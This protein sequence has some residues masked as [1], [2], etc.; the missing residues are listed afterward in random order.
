[1]GQAPSNAILMGDIIG[2]ERAEMAP[3]H[4]RFNAE[5]TRRNAALEGALVS[6]LTITLGDEF[7]GLFARLEDAARTARDMRLALLEDGVACRFVIGQARID[8][9]VNAERA[10]NMMGPGLGRAR[11]MLNEKRP[12]Q[13]YR[14]SLPDAPLTQTLLEAIGRAMGVIERGWTAQQRRDIAA[15]LGG[16]SA[17]D[18]AAARQV[19][20][21][22]VYKVL[23]AG[24]YDT[25]AA[26]W[27]AA[28]DALAALDA[29]GV[30]K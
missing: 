16:A 15:A 23:R 25:Y 11:D 12:H 5:I 9:P 17:Q 10:W 30:G 28:S 26:L 20:D 21:H 27:D 13:F 29:E 19:Q 8:T 14:F 3:L 18:I 24:D 4:A 2:S 22:S 1:M 7:Q 6:P